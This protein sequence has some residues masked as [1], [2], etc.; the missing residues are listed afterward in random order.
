MTCSLEDFCGSWAKADT[1]PPPEFLGHFAT[2]A[3]RNHRFV[4]ALIVH[5]HTKPFPGDVSDLSIL[6]A[7]E[8][9]WRSPVEFRHCSR[10]I[11]RS[12]QGLRRNSY[13]RSGCRKPLV[14]HHVVHEN[15]RRLAG[16]NCFGR[17]SELAI[18]FYFEPAPRKRRPCSVTHFARL[19]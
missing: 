5:V 11:A 19:R 2:W 8:R 18:F 10:P 9:I 4:V 6:Q 14:W 7:L 3:I 1:P 13:E 15:D 16:E 17:K 12:Q